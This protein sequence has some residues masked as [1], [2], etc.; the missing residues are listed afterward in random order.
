MVE[1][2]DWSTAVYEI[3][4]MGNAVTARMPVLS[5]VSLVHV[6]VWH[7]YENG[8]E[9]RIYLVLQLVVLAMCAYKEAASKAG[10]VWKCVLMVCGVQCVTTLGTHL[11]LVLS[12]NNLDSQDLV[13]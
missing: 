6:T 1:R 7:G 5:V 8:F 3:S 9:L 10:V 4:E 2:V 11:M 12:A 13:L